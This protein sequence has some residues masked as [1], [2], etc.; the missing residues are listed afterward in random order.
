M[1]I[2]I[3]GNGHNSNITLATIHE[4][5]GSFRKDTATV[6]SQVKLMQEALTSQGY[7]T[8]GADGKF[9]DNTLSAVKAFQRAK[10]LTVDGYFGKNSLLA[11]ENDIGH[12]LDPTNCTSSGG[13][14]SVSQLITTYICVDEMGNL[15]KPSYVTDCFSRILRDN[16]LRRIRFHD[17]RHP[18]VKHTTKIFIL[19][20]KV[21]QAQRDP[22][23]R[24]KT[25]G[26]FR[27]HRKGLKAKLIEPILQ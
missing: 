14:A 18:Y 13:N 7:N 5:N 6:H 19:R 26:A 24:R 11:L 8:Q 20:L 3:S 27:L 17:L 22:D 2:S 21:L 16:N 25:C 10:G 15:I 12:H 4:G 23:R 1:A 9:G